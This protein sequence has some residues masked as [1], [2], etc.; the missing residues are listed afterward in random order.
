MAKLS[1]TARN[2]KRQ[3]LEKKY[4]AKRAELK[5]LARQSYIQGDIP[6][7]I[8]RQLQEMPRNSN[9]TRVKRRCQCC[10]R[11]RSIYRKFGLCRLCLRKYAMMGYV[12]GLVKASW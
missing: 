6:W 2:E 5:D 7:D 11:P 8:H 3:A 1:V 12:P 9:F 10:G 4:R